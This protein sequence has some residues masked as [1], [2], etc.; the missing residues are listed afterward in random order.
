MHKQKK[1]NENENWMKLHS[2]KSHRQ[3]CITIY[4]KCYN[5]FNNILFSYLDKMSV[6]K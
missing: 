2:F 1:V 4:D 5:V 6:W 3:F